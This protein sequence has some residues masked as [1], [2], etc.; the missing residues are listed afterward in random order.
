MISQSY[1]KLSKFTTKPC[2]QSFVFQ[3]F[4]QKNLVRLSVMRYLQVLKLLS[5]QADDKRARLIVKIFLW[6]L[7][8]TFDS[9]N[10]IVTE[11]RRQFPR[12]RQP[13]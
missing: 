4:L 9:T 2:E 3:D 7:T 8:N 11:I 5:A 10:I 6:L 1:S 13:C 12:I